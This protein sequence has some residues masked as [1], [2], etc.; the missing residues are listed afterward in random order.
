MPMILP[1]EPPP[2]VKRKN[3]AQPCR[4]SASAGA[5]QMFTEFAIM[6]CASF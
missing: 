1:H 5:E 2:S 4:A 6:P 3:R